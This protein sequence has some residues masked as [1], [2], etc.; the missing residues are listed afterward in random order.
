MW[1]PGAGGGQKAEINMTPMIDV[2]LVLIIIFMVI[3]PIASRGLPALVP[4]NPPPGPSVQ[5]APRNDIVVSIHSDGGLFLNQEAI[6]LPG[7]DQRLKK[8][9]RNGPADVVFV[10][11]DK[12]IEFRRVADV[13]DVVRGAGVR[14]IGLMT[15]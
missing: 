10:R 2:L 7:L 6:D 9:F 5:Q 4:E 14:S 1:T 8:L 3:T 13:V 15:N 12:Q 11:G